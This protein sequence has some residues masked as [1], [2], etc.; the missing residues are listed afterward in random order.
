MQFIERAVWF[1]ENR[2]GEDITLDDIADVGGV[3]RF[4]LS[5]SFGTLTGQSVI[6]YVRGRRLT[7][8]AE[9]LADGAPD[10]LSV[11]LDVGY[12]SHEAFTRAFRD[13]FGQTPEQV[14]A[15]GVADPT[16]LVEPLRIDETPADR[17]ARAAHRGRPPHARG[18]LCRA[19][20]LRRPTSG[21]PALWQRFAPHIGHMPGQRRRRHL[22]RRR[23]FRGGLHRSA[24][25]PASR[26][27]PAADLDEGM[28]YIDVP[29]QRYAVFAHHGPH[30]DHAPHRLFDLGA[31]LSQQRARS[32]PA[33]PSFRAL[34]RRARSANR[35]WPGGGLGADCR[36]GLGRR[37]ARSRAMTQLFTDPAAPDATTQLEEGTAF[38][39]RFD[40]AGLVTVVTIE[41]GSNDVLMLAHMNAE[42]LALTLETGIAH[43]WSRSRGKLWKKGETSGEVQKVVELRTDCDQD[44]IVLVGQPDRP[45]RRLPHRAQD[46]LLSAGRR[47]SER[48]QAVARK[49]PACR[50]LFD[51]KARL[52]RLAASSRFSNSPTINIPAKKPAQMRLPGDADLRARQQRQQ[53]HGGV[54]QPP[55][56][57][58]TSRARLSR[59]RSPKSAS[60]RPT[61]TRSPGLGML[62]HDHRLEDEAHRRAGQPGHAARGA[63]QVRR[64][65]RASSP[66]TGPR[67]PLPRRRR[68]PASA[69][70]RSAAPPA[71]RKWRTRPR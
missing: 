44:A 37:A 22:W 62:R 24:I 64:P 51:P 16:S 63:D 68:S 34:W 38:A 20:H 54:E 25:S 59:H 46:L 33:A 53:R 48:R 7:G 69:L 60:L 66:R 29:A 35:P 17:P 50:R 1:I 67:R 61:T 40:A 12:G 19:L 8:A 52:R 27:R 3:S 10:I 13:Q 70:P 43:Y 47:C 6:G 4:H 41:A 36:A 11:A 31:I 30:L 14:R 23:R 55:R 42:A 45:R 15:H 65:N 9:K 26:S 21:I 56:S 5:R 18:R 32:R 2:F 49:I 28:G 58:R 71:S 57:G 39:P